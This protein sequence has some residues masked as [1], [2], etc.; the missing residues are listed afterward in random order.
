MSTKIS[1]NGW[2]QR[3]LE[4]AAAI[5]QQQGSRAEHQAQGEQFSVLHESPGKG[6]EWPEA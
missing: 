1:K 4:K 5:M 3:I 2:R 6:G